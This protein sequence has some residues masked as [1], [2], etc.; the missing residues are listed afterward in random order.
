MLSTS[1]QTINPTLPSSAI[2]EA[3]FKLK[4]FNS[5][6]LLKQNEAF[7]NYLQN[8]ITVSIQ[9]KAETQYPIVKLIDF[10]H[11]ENNSFYAINQ[12]TVEEN[13]V[14]RPDVVLFVNG[15]PLVVI[16]LKSCS[17]ENTD[18]SFAYNQ[19]RNYLHDIPTLFA[20]NAF[21]VLSDLSTSRAGTITSKEDRYMEWKT[22]TGDYE[23]TKYATFNVLFEGMFE[24]NRFLEILHYFI[25]FAEQDKILAGYHQ[26]FAVK[27]AIE[28][29][30]EATQT[31]GKGGIFWHTQGSGKSLSMVFYA[32]LLQIALNQPT[33][34]VITDRNDLDDQLYGTF[35]RCA[36]Y[37]RQNPEQAE[38]RIDLKKLLDGRVANGIIFTTMQKFEESAEPLSNRRNIILIADEA[39]RS[40]YGL[41]ER[42]D[43]KTGKVRSG[44]ARLVRDSLPNATFIGFT[45]TPIAIKEKSTMEVF[46][47]YIDVY[48][49]TQSVAD[50]ATRP[51]FYESRV[52]N[53]GLRE[54]VLQQIDDYY[55]KIAPL[56]DPGTIE[57]SK[58]DLSKMDAILGAESTV[59]S[60]CKDI[61]AHYEGR[62][63]LLTGKAMIVAYSRDIAMRIYRKILEL[64]PGWSEKV[65]VVMTGDNND[66]EDW[67]EIVGQKTY[68]MEL[69]SKFKNDLDEMKIAIVVDMW[70]TGFDIPSLATMYIYKPMVGHNLMQAIAR[71]NRVFGDKEGGLVVDYVG[72][73]SALKQAMLDYTRRD[74][75]NYGEMDIAKVA[76]P[77]FREKLQVCKD[78]FYGFDLS[79]FEN[80]TDLDR[81]MTIVG[82]INFILDQQADRV[83]TKE[84]FVKEA[85]YLKQSGSL[86]RSMMTR[87]E[88]FESAFFEA[89]RSSI[90]KI[91]TDKKFSL[92]EINDRVNEL[93]KQSIKSEGVINLFEGVKVE[94][95][96]FDPKFLEDIAKMQ[97]KN[98][99]AELLKKL[100]NEQLTIFKR[101]NVVQSELFS[102]KMERI[103]NR[104][105]NGQ[106]SNVEVIEELKRLA[107]E[108]AKNHKAGE[109]LGLTVEEK[110]FYDALTK[111]EAI[112]DYYENDQLVQ[113]TK[114]LT[115]L[116]REKRTVDWQKKE[117]ARAEMRSMVK[118]LL[119]KY[120]Y[121]PAGLEDALKI[122]ITQCEMWT[123][124]GEG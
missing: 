13:A 114:E 87:A 46:G 109:D 91:T 94:F 23:E 111:P 25:L 38:N 102:K 108:I 84:L 60:L 37:L 78:L 105:R 16:E 62:Q 10:E 82:G 32:K 70:L 31:D 89:V 57:K 121:P 79:K 11:P 115:E 41:T 2:Q 61:I 29:T 54:D 40:Q 34:V 52:I 4:N 50:G 55:D 56:A 47:D 44:M 26:Y 83:K 107:E 95:S 67:K 42:I 24:K 36:R 5:I 12:W 30:V 81:A 97:Q 14:K 104:Y 3:I 85:Q 39:H 64:R 48:D 88:R 43:P 59:T 122:V 20:Y 58:K 8:G 123:D 6:D 49:M 77:K 120:K 33:I 73:A 119:K 66:P 98:L 71:V 17:R 113:I 100:I 124:E 103:M 99:A 21:C 53:I 51:V 19:L 45:G 63:D 74:Q 7:I 27:K 96:I 35:S 18:T 117:M 112:K 101:S 76:Y 69:A 92:K 90:T 93:L 118:R 1:L 110:A 22:I 86:C 28:R 65:K 80:G 72:L 68:R 15:L 75:K 9:E 116:L 106:I